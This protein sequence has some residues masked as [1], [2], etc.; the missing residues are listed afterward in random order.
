MKRYC[1]LQLKRA[2]KILPL[3]LASVLVM[4]LCIALVASTL[5][6]NEENSEENKRFRI[7]IT[8]DTDGT[9]VQLGM[10]ALKTFDDTR[11]AMDLVELTEE[12]AKEQLKTNRIS[13]YVVLPKDFI[14]RAWYGDVDTVTY[15]TYTG[16]Q[17]LF[18]L[19]KNEITAL[20]TDIVVYTEKAPY[21]LADA[22]RE[23]GVDI[24]K[25]EHVEALSLEFVNLIF[26]RSK[27]CTAEE[28]GISAGVSTVEYYLGGLSVFLLAVMG[29][30]FVT[31]HVKSDRA[32]EQLLA[33]KGHGSIVQVLCETVSHFVVLATLVALLLLLG[34]IAL[35]V[36]GKPF[37]VD[38]LPASLLVRMVAVLAMIASFNIMMFELS[39]SVVNVV[40]LHF[41][42]CI[43]Q[44]YA[45]GCFYP[46]YALPLPLQQ[47]SHVLPC[48]V[49]REFLE[50]S[51]LSQ[52]RLGQLAML[53]IFTGIFT[54]IT[55][56]LRDRKV[57]QHQR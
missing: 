14:E 44:C 2:F 49:A 13:A 48:G 8:G 52:A 6:K 56:L 17:D 11:F 50:G 54:A 29:I 1:Y 37:P 18:T 10:A 3:V 55:V 57:L 53:L 20:V 33:S 24:S 36:T 7:A 26:S 32:F 45:C 40:L 5:L 51:F 34:G 19:F 41:V 22:I 27:L 16:S 42:A 28:L 30:A 39:D 25:N 4:L 46:M 23:S 12:E 35:W 43:G 38:L 9:Y 31:V 15:V 47:L 21:A